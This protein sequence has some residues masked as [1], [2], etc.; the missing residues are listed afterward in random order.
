MNSLLPGDLFYNFI[1]YNVHNTL[2]PKSFSTPLLV[3]SLNSLTYKKVIMERF[4]KYSSSNAG[5]GVRGERQRKGWNWNIV[6]CG[7]KG[8]KNCEALACVCVRM[9]PPKEWKRLAGRAAVCTYGR[10][11]LIVSSQGLAAPGA[12]ANQHARGKKI[13]LIT[14]STSFTLYSVGRYLHAPRIQSGT[15]TQAWHHTAPVLITLKKKVLFFFYSRQT[16]PPLSC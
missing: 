10:Q 1:I 14:P 15:A 6:F 16:L 12:K 2:L 8:E 9:R 13:T 3:D 11:L 7:K 4:D 5:K